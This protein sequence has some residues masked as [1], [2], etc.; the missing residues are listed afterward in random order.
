MINVRTSSTNVLNP[1]YYRSLSS[2]QIIEIIRYMPFPVGNAIKYIYRNK[3][4]DG[5]LQDLKKA[6]W[7]L[8]DSLDNRVYNF[9][10]VEIDDY[11]L[12]DLFA[13]QGDFEKTTIQLIIDALKDEELFEEKISLAVQ[14][15]SE[16]IQEI[17]N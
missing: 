3:N 6:L 11:I 17:D 16:K 4:K 15:V 14:K 1:A 7:Y 9:Q 2:F 8:N 13:H 5:V 10:T 12:E